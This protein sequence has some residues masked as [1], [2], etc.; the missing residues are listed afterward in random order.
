MGYGMSVRRPSNCIENA[1]RRAREQRRLP[2]PAVRRRLRE[3]AGLRQ[4]DIA[5]AL[6]VRRATIARYENGTRTPRD[7]DVAAAYVIV[8]GRLSRA[9]RKPRGR[10]HG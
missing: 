5:L 10:A 9:T 1:L 8:L 6:G 3:R 2:P 4:L 7:P